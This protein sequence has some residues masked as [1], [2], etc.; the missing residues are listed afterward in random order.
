MTG[1]D[2][3]P[4]I[5][6]DID[7]LVGTLDTLGYRRN[8]DGWAHPQGRIAAFLG[9]FIDMGTSNRAVLEIVRRMHDSGNAFAVMGNHELNAILFHSPG[10]NEDDPDCGYMRAHSPKNQDQHRNFLEEFPLGGPE[11]AEIIAWFMTLPLVRELD[12]IRLAHACWDDRQ[13]ATILKRRPNGRL[14]TEDF[15][16][17]AF[18]KGAERFA[19]AVLTVLKGR[20]ERLPAGYSFHDASGH[21]RNEI[22]LKWWVNRATNRREVAVS[23]PDRE[24]L[25]DTPLSPEIRFEPYDPSAKPVFFGHYKLTDA[26]LIETHNALCLDYPGTACAYRWSGEMRLMEENLVMIT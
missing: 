18:E 2:I 11:T 8:A 22:R 26:P 20:E 24:Q 25:P 23:V 10:H 15:Q 21:Q 7:R 19:A 5:H 17:I 14:R 9:D 13:I 4:D 6:A 16:Q 12:G 1:Y 3:I